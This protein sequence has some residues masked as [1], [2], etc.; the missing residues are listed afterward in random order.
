MAKRET[1]PI[2]IRP[3]AQSDIPALATIRSREWETV[4]FWKGRIGAYMTA[5]H[6]P[7][8]VPPKAQSARA[9]FVATEEELVI[10]FVAGHVTKRFD[11]DAELQWINVIAEKRG[12]GIAALLIQAIA[13]WFVEQNALRVRVDPDEP[14]RALYARLGAT[15]LN[16]HWMV[17]ED[18]REMLRKARELKK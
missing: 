1:M 12:Q 18:S 4:D 2:A 5:Q 6:S 11:C 9:V 13:V 15:E 7:P 10:G 16:R 8:N 17:W 3:A 14:A